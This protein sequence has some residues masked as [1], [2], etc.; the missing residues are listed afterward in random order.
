[1]LTA[2]REVSYSKNGGTEPSSPEAAC[3]RDAD[4]LDAYLRAFLD[5]FLAERA[6]E[7]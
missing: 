6:G 3:V 2:I 1:M 7:R 4:R 5:E